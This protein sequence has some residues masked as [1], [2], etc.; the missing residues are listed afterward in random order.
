[1][2]VAGCGQQAGA[3]ALESTSSNRAASVWAVGDGADGGPQGRALAERIA[4]AKPDRFLYL[5]DVYQNGTANE[6]ARHY[7]TTYGRL[8]SITAPT[9][10]NHD[11]PL[12]GEGYDDYWHRALERAVPPF[13]KFSIGGWEILSLNSEIPHDQS[14]PQLRWLREG[15]RACRHLQ[16][17][18]LASPAGERRLARQRSGPRP[19]L[20][21][22]ERPR[23]NRPRRTRP[24][25]AAFSPA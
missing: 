7:A 21:R 20:E 19:A 2:L 24:R 15:H 22:V 10:G 5:G 8:A 11:W 16:A 23:G 13:Y 18:V 6:F 14:S 9:P 25:H 4:R 17:R 3:R 12:H 1:L